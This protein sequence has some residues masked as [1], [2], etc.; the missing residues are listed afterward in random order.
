MPSLLH[1]MKTEMLPVSNT[2]MNINAICD[3]LVTYIG[4]FVIRKNNILTSEYLLPKYVLYLIFHH[5]LMNF[6]ERNNFR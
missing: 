2:A 5:L 3:I 1:D 6:T 4:I